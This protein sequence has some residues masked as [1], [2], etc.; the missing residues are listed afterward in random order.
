MGKKVFIVCGGTGGHLAPGI[1]TA[2]RLMDN[3]VSVELIVS[4]KEV[5]SR[6]LQAYP[7]L[8]FR[9]AAG[10]PFSIMPLGLLRFTWKNLYSIIAAL[11]NLRRQRPAMVLAFGGFVSV[12]YAGAAWL[13]NIPI[14]LHE[15]N[16]TVGR[17]IRFLSGMADSIFL[18]D[19]VSLPGIEP[20]RLKR[21]EMPLRKEVQHISKDIVRERLGI[22]LHAKVLT[23]VGGSQGAQVL[24]EWVLAHYKS[25]AADGIW[26]MLVTGQGKALLPELEVLESDQGAR[27]EL[28]SFGFH[29]RLYELFSCADVVVSRAGAGSISELAACLTPSILIPYPSAADDHQ[30]LNARYVECRGG[31]ILIPQYSIDNLYREVLDLIYN[32]WLLGRMRANLRRMLQGDAAGK[33]ARFIEREYILNGAR[34]VIPNEAA[35]PPQTEKAHG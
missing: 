15:A 2:Q 6:L 30:F 5:D 18:P 14:I 16:R 11:R 10:A 22:P 9:K 31:A 12:S 35:K 34:P 26:I 25:L 33:L 23:V 13:L 21:L 20:R 4:N 32:D 19:G 27:V 24:N 7:D 3:G 29:D 28:R 1:A 8:P 17:S